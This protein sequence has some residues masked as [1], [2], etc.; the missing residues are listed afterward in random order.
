MQRTLFAL[1][2]PDTT[3][4]PVTNEHTPDMDKHADN[5]VP[6]EDVNSLKAE[7][8]KLHQHMDTTRQTLQSAL[9]RPDIDGSEVQ[10][11]NGKLAIVAKRLVALTDSYRS[12][13]NNDAWLVGE[14]E[15]DV[16]LD[17]SASE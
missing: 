16:G 17:V 2:T 6:D 1:P 4:A 13:L 9:L 11:I 7:I 8:D 15:E 5:S 3:P 10:T 14:F 12:A